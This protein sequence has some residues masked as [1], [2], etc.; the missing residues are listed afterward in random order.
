M[1]ALQVKV[2]QVTGAAH[3]IGL[4]IAKRFAAHRTIPDAD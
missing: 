2:A 1:A 3:G 4:A